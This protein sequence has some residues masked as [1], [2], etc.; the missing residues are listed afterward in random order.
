MLL[1]NLCKSFN[2]TIVTT[3]EKPIL[4][5]LEEVRLYF[6]KRIEARREFVDR[7][8]SAIGLRIQ[9]ILDKNGKLSR[10]EW[11]EYA[12]KEKLRVRHNAGIVL[13]AI[14]LRARTSIYCAW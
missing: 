7:W 2:S 11:A 14:D 3:R 1:N 5:I 12:G 6:M 4:T 10:F 13:H 8:T 9:N